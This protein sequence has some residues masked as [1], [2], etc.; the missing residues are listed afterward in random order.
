[1]PDKRCRQRRIAKG[2]CGECGH[3]AKSDK[4]KI[5]LM[6]HAAVD[7]LGNKSKW[8]I[9]NDMLVAQNKRCK[10]CNISID[11]GEGATVG[12]LK[13]IS[14]SGFSRK[15]AKYITQKEDIVIICGPCN[16][17]QSR[18]SYS[19][20]IRCCISIA[21]ENNGKDISDI[22]DADA[23]YLSKINDICVNLKLKE[24][25]ELQLQY[26][27]HADAIKKLIKNLNDTSLNET[28]LETMV[29]IA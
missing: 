14:R 23:K 20:F 22:D 17:M 15:E 11:F 28:L 21:V 18:N 19:E 16:N 5:C 26:K 29:N 10:Y 13:S 12:H 9:L 3:P 7:H 2:L 4:H 24:E 6:R 27:L 25:V 8:K 1:M